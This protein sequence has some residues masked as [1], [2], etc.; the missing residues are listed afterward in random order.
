[1]TTGC[2]YEFLVDIEKNTKTLTYKLTNSF[3]C[4]LSR[5]YQENLYELPPYFEHWNLI[6]RKSDILEILENFERG[7]LGTMRSGQIFERGAL[8]S[9][10]KSSFF[11]N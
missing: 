10:T 2:D 7:A 3:L 1:M 4:F 5:H 8:F 9:Q 6:S 11:S